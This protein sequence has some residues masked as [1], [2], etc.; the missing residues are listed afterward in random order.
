[1]DAYNYI[2]KIIKVLYNMVIFLLVLFCLYL[3]IWLFRFYSSYIYFLKNNHRTP[4]SESVYKE[5]TIVQPIVSGDPQLAHFLRRNIETNENVNFVWVINEKDSEAEK[6][7]TSLINE[8]GEDRLQFTTVGE[9]PAD[10]ND[11]VIKQMKGLEFAKKYFIAVDDDTFVN[12]DN[13]TLIGDRLDE[14][15]IYSGLP[16]YKSGG[17]F[18]MRIVSAFSNGNSVT[19]Y[20]PMAYLNQVSTA[21][22]MF[23]L[24]HSDLLREYKIFDVSKSFLCDEYEIAKIL[25]ENNVKIIQTVMP[26]EIS[27][28]VKD[29]K[30]Y[31]SLMKRWMVFSR[32]YI[33]ENSSPALLTLVVSPSIL[34]VLAI[35]GSLFFAIGLLPVFLIL[36]WCKTFLHKKLRHKILDNEETFSATFF[37]MLSEYLMPFHFLHSLI[38][39]NVIIWRKRKIDVSKKIIHYLDD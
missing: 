13:L 19:S 6:I 15:A 9:P 10:Q 38:S 29:L 4:I 35:L 21:N 2:N 30:H 25:E 39:P 37:E 1:M 32:V 26:C 33:K 16:Y 23:Y 24:I 18:L 11:K 28:S 3:V 14:R 5:M 7:V 20:L 8:F 22:G 17:S 12:L 27:T 36:H 34:L 31:I